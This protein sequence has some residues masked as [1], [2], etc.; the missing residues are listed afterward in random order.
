MGVT[1]RLLPE[2]RAIDLNATITYK[3][4][5]QDTLHTIYLTDWA[6]SFSSKQSPL[7]KH[8]TENYEKKFHLARKKD[9]G[10]TQINAIYDSG[11]SVHYER[12]KDH[13][14]IIEVHLKNPLLPGASYKLNLVYKVFLPN[15]RFTKYGV[16]RNRDY[17]LRFWFITPAIYNGE[18]H[19]YSNKNLNDRYFPKSNININLSLPKQYSVISD[20]DTQVN[21]SSFSANEK[22]AL[23][24]GK[25]RVD[26]K[27]LIVQES[28]F[29]AI[30]T[31]HLTIITNLKDKK[32][33][34]QQRALIADRI[35][36]FL[37]DNL[38]DYPHERLLVSDID[39]RENPVYGFNEL[40][41]F[42]TPFPQGFEYELKLLKTTLGN[43][44]N[45]TILVNPRKDH[46]TLEGIKIFLFMHYI[47]T[48]YPDL[49]AIGSLSKYW[50]VRQ[51]YGA[52]L[53]F[54]D[55]FRLLY[56]HSA[57]LNI[58]QASTTARDSLNKFNENIASANKSGAGLYYL[59]EYI[60]QDTVLQSI[61]EFYEAYNLKMI[62][63]T[64]FENILKDA[65][66]KDIDWFF[67]DY[68]STRKKID[69]TITKSKVIDDS[70]YVTI[71]NKRDHKAPIALY[72][73]KED[74][75]VSKQWIT[76][77]KHVETTKVFPKDSVDEF[78]LNYNNAAPEINNRNNYEKPKAF[79]GINKPFH[80]KLLQDFENPA[81]NQ[82]FVIPTFDFNVY[83]GFSPGFSAFNKTIL[84]KKLN[85]KIEPQY[86]LRSNRIIG[87]ASISYRHDFDYGKLR[88]L[89]YGIAANTASFAED[90][91][92][93]RFIPFVRFTFKPR[94]FRSDK[95][96]TLNARLVSVQRD[97]S[98]ILE[99]VEPDYSVFNLRYTQRN[100]GI[101][102]TFTWAVDFQQ[103]DDFS[104]LSATL[105]YR[106]L[107]LNNRQLNL[108]FFAG[109]FLNNNTRDDGDF[110]SFALD[111]PTDYL[112]DFNYYARSDDSGF[113]SQQIIIA[114]GGFK[115]R[116]QPAFANE[117]IVT[118]NASTTIWKYVYAYADF[119]V[120]KNLGQDAEF[121][122]DSG[123]Q[124]SLLDDF[125]EF[126]F[127]V[128][129][130]LG[131][132]IG[133]QNYGERIRFT[134]TI[135]LDTVI[136]LFSRTV[137]YTHLTLPTIL[138]V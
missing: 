35:S 47:D 40:P 52:K 17:R 5:S 81:K 36:Y 136:R 105:F 73:L 83:D 85:Y 80:F 129:S 123:I 11:D 42:I 96:K 119:G 22:I 121:V 69:Y 23:L 3:N 67:G 95:S 12:L 20:L 61:K 122:Y 25:D 109:A 16:A 97:D 88:A 4:E 102:N 65:T 56:L 107:Y 135:G 91:R 113:L 39:Y 138:L 18:W 133:E 44:V 115:S 78:I 31:D 94:D 55:Q 93:R 111:R 60:G 101:I 125:F 45:N 1:A 124:V 131:F 104:K 114:E 32:I 90:L 51:F 38:G 21:E 15:A 137:S 27:V 75:I 64:H 34:P 26:A 24:K 19:Y 50:I 70:V 99:Q 58:D 30:E 130:N 74:S 43:Y 13:L 54:N 9:R 134:A 8:F 77:P 57:R 66:Q 76:S 86:G 116:L 118:T 49:K 89:R 126:Y 132:E 110:F 128:Y 87:S 106:R 29:E 98:P 108:R 2:E 48:Y 37:N 6:H 120:V 62:T 41:S 33:F 112:F 53:K 7:A 79:L 71:K 28:D 46:W 14:D 72:A 82:A 117:W 92:F 10:R 63:P 127:P 68:L 84:T 59:G 103:A 100:P